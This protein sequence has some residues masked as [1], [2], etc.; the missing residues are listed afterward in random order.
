LRL[1]VRHVSPL[2]LLGIVAIG[3]CTPPTALAPSL[4]VYAVEEKS[5]ATLQ[6]DLTA[7]RVTSEVLV[8]AYLQRIEAIDRNGPTLRS[9]LSV[10]PDAAAQARLLDDERRAGRVRGPLHGIPILLKDNIDTKDPLPTTAG[11]LALAANVTGRDAP[12]VARLRDAGAIVLG[13]TNLSEWA[14]IRS[15]RSTSGWSAVGGL[16]RN[17]YALD[18]NTCGSSAGS[19]AAAAASL[20]AAAIGT[21]TDGSIVCPSAANGLVGI[22][23]TVGLVSRT[24]IVPISHSQDTPGPMAR[25]VGDA[26]ILL[27]VM[28]GHDALDVATK[29]ADTRRADYPGALDRD[30]LRGVRLAALRFLGGYHAETDRVFDAALAAMKV[31]GADIVDV[32]SFDRRAEVGE[33]ELTILLT[34]LKVDLDAYLASTPA[35]VQTRSLADVIAFNKG[36]PAEMVHF[37]QELFERAAATRGLRDPAYLGALEKARRLAGP[38]GIDRMLQT[39]GAVALLAPTG[40]PAWMTDVID[41]DHFL[42]AA[43]ELPAVAGYPHVTVPMGVVSG[44]PVGISFI[45]GAWSEARLIGLAYAFEQHARAR[46]PPVYPPSIDG[47]KPEAPTAR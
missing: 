8:A 40:G 33:A 35:Q 44:L 26:A 28:A 3:A 15:S 34:E 19:G 31:A 23:P 22:K 10:N 4:E 17:P 36:T 1:A 14:N 37:G 12:A 27:A 5:I 13:K 38:E 30:A 24:H 2:A 29:D 39:T 45:G 41:G 32:M 7:G 21:E 6:A 47:L 11:S 16:T 42:G 25:S 18:R 46:I 43:S 9:V 20:A